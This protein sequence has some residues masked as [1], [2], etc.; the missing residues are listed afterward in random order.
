MV[1]MVQSRCEEVNA[2]RCGDERAG[3]MVG[4]RRM[5]PQGPED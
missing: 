5:E 3:V 1:A 2:G 4:D